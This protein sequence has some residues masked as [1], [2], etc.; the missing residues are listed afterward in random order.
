MHEIHTKTRPSAPFDSVR[1]IEGFDEIS[2]NYPGYLTDESKFPGAMVDML[3]LP[4]DESEL[5]AVFRAMAS[6]QTPVT[7]AGARTGLVG[8]CVPLCG[9]LVSLERLDGIRKV[10]YDEFAEEWRVVAQCGVSLRELN[11]CVSGK[12]FPGIEREADEDAKQHLARFR[13]DPQSYF[14]PPDPTELSASIGGTVATNASGARTYR[15]GSTRNWVRKIRVML[16]SGEFLDIPRGKYFASPAREFVIY[17]STGT[18][19]FVRTPS[20]PLP[21]TKN[22]AGIFSA[23]NMDLIDLFIGSEGVFGVITEVEVALCKRE[24]K[25]SVIQFVDSDEVAIELVEAL[26]ADKRIPFDFIEFYSQEAVNLLRQRQERDPKSVGMPSIPPAMKSAVFVEFSFDPEVTEIDYSAFVETAGQCGVDIVNSWAGYESRELERFKAFRHILP[27]TV[28]EIIAQR[29]KEHPG[30]HKLGT[31]LAVPRDC[32]NEMWQVYMRGLGAAGLQ[33][34]AF[35]HIG[36]NHVHVNILPRD[37]QELDQGMHLYHEFA[38]KAV[39][40]GG[41]VSAEHGI[42]KIKIPYLRAMFDARQIEEMRHI[43]ESLDPLGILNPGD[44]FE[45]DA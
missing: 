41:T 9:A 33:W 3:F 11:Q 37:M 44:I 7:V 31:D 15:Y 19:H 17:D 14:Y 45:V 4:K 24:K 18:P 23:P 10:Y 30:L 35:G 22:T 1:R 28:N 26:R 36:N 8:G 20:Y 27:E 32:L 42:G 5:S 21:D 25:V 2:R 34:L 39:E 43:K 12:S 13:D 16:A 6:S 40:L 38:R 29:K